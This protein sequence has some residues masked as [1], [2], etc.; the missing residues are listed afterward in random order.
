LSA[1]VFPRAT[2]HVGRMV[3]VAQAVIERG[4]AYQPGGNVY[5]RV[6]SFGRC[7]ELGGAVSS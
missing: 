1:D 3:E 6:A 4:Y 5:F 7:G 2:D